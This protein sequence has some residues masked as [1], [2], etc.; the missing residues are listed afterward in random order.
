MDNNFANTQAIIANAQSQA[1]MAAARKAKEISCKSYMSSFDPKTATVEQMQQYAECVDLI[2]P[3]PMSHDDMIAAK[4]FFALALIGMIVC[5]GW[6]LYKHGLRWWEDALLGA[7]AGFFL[8]P[9]G[10]GII[11]GLIA[12]IFWL[13]GAI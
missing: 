5:G 10:V 1:A 3:K 13:F 7:L 9:I 11:L 12:G 8:V 2:H 4:F 6:Q